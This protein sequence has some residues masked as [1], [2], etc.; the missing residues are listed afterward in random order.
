L[1]INNC[2]L[3]HNTAD[4]QRLIVKRPPK[5]PDRV[6][7]VVNNQEYDRVYDWEDRSS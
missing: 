1:F 6:Y 3:T 7:P 5:E 2:H 4:P